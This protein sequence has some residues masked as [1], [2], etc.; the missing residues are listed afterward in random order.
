MPYWNRSS[1]HN[2]SQHNLL[3]SS[4]AEEPSQATSSVPSGASPGAGAANPSSA[5]PNSAFSSGS[6]DSFQIDNGAAGLNLAQ[7][8]QP[9]PSHLVNIYNNPASGPSH[10]AD[11]VP[12]LQHSNTVTGVVESRQRD[13]DFQ[14]Q[15]ARSHSHRF[16]QISPT[17]AQ[18]Q[19]HTNTYCPK[20][21]KN[22]K[23]QTSTDKTL[24]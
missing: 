13:H 8:S 3:G 1:K 10:F 22:D 6:N 17:Q 12:Q 4:V 7:A 5:L 20:T 15:V 16:P 19:Q 21:D 18:Q 24:R 23:K 11:P 9:Q 14:D 2:R